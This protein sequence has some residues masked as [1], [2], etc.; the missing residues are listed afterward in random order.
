V[1][2]VT[3]AGIDLELSA[4]LI[5]SA[6]ECATTRYGPAYNDDAT[7]PAY[8][9]ITSFW[10]IGATSFDLNLIDSVSSVCGNQDGT[11]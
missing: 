2:T 4:V 9:S 6:C 8:D 3:S 10:G 11:T 1:V 7:F 5:L